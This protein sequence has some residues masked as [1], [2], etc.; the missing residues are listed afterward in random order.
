MILKKIKLENF[1][2]FQFLELEF[3]ENLIGIIGKNGA[4]KS[5][6]IEALGW[7]LYGTRI[8]RTDKQDIRSQFSTA[9]GGCSV[10]LEFVY[11]DTEYRI[12]RK[13]KGKNAITEAAI[14]C[15]GA[16]A[17][18]AVQERGVNEYVENL[19][20][21]DYRSFLVSVYA[22][23]KELAALSIMQ[24]EERRRSINRLIGID[25]IDEARERL[26]KDRNDQEKIVQGMRLSLIDVELLRQRQTA[27]QEQ[28]AQSEKELQQLSAQLQAKRTALEGAK[29]GF[30]T[31]SKL[32]DQ[33]ALLA[34]R[35][36][37]DQTR[38]HEC[39]RTNQRLQAELAV[40]AEAE[41]ELVQMQPLVDE[42][43]AIRGKKEELDQMALRKAKQE[44]LEASQLQ[45]DEG[46][47]KLTEEEQRDSAALNQYTALLSDLKAAIESVGEAEKKLTELQ[48]HYTEW[49]ARRTSAETHGREWKEKYATLQKLGPEGTCP[50]CT[51]PL[52]DHYEVALLEINEKIEGLRSEF[53][54]ARQQEVTLL[55]SQKQ[56]EREL[57]KLRRQKEGL[58]QRQ[59]GLEEIKKRFASLQSEKSGL[60][61]KR[62]RIREQLAA[63]GPVS[64][65]SGQHETWKNKY[66]AAQKWLQKQAQLLER[67]R[68]RPDLEQELAQTQKNRIEIV[69]DIAETEAAQVALN[70][71]EAA[72]QTAKNDIAEKT[73][74]VDELRDNYS[75]GREAM[76]AIKKD[77]QSV[78]QT[79]DEQGQKAEEIKNREQ[80]VQYL[81]ALD[82]HLGRFRLALAGRI[83]PLL[84]Q[85]ASELL[86]LT[87]NNRYQWLDLDE[88]Y[89]IRVYDGNESFGIDR[90]SGGEQDLVNL[91]LRIAISQV[92]AERSGGYPVNLLVLDEVFA[93]QDEERKGCI[94]ESLGRLTSQFRQ[95]FMITHIEAIKEVLPVILE[96]RFQD[97][98][99]S[100]AVWR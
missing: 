31:L 8:S 64:Y 3:P 36:I 79:I 87:S 1:R 19:L 23:Q 42:Y 48:S 14:Y 24:P 60:E 93:S 34:T 30:E 90:F 92:V 21:L 53:K 4:G 97:E 47:Q 46:W 38:L 74:Q 32:R 81:A 61:Q 63:L 69:Q 100:E 71:N 86:A 39:E 6:L 75:H 95:I 37:K 35:L 96:V 2:R 70:F 20:K 26:R 84:A 91:C 99:K 80:E 18:A 17:P 73:Q 57:Q 58:L 13:I 45:L 43:N 16:E 54:Y 52:R 76:A 62:Q 50:T 41:E 5:S 28:L 94:L 68:R 29:S 33:H 59:A 67:V 55:E 72:F 11:G 22:R 77:L 15:S 12:L 10:E 66:E 65:D 49:S 7:A 85:R 82:I 83:R 56:Q 88:D 25:E 89:N 98:E 40:I 78:G 27:L 51:Q 44:S 9:S